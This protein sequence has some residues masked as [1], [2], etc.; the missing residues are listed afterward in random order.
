M[1]PLLF[2]SSAVICE[3]AIIGLEIR[4]MVSF[5]L[6]NTSRPDH[7]TENELPERVF[8]LNDY[9][10]KFWFSEFSQWMDMM[11]LWCGVLR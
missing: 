5:L 8:S 2:L 4:E 9:F 1:H 3:E 10:L 11:E 7:G 6:P